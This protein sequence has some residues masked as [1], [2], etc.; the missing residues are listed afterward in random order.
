MEVKDLIG[1]I[2]KVG[3]KVSW[4]EKS[5]TST[6][7]I[8]YGEISLIEEKPYQ[9]IISVSILKCG[10]KWNGWNK[11]IRRFIFPRNYHNLIKV[12]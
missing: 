6:A 8:N 10:H 3:D 4:G 2:L 11:G 1:N 12:G 9:T 7:Y 5:S